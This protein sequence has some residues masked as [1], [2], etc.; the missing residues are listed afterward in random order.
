M[1]WGAKKPK[2][3][4]ATWRAEVILTCCKCGVSF[5][6]GYRISAKRAAKPQYCGLECRS[7]K[8]DKACET[9][10]KLFRPRSVAKTKFCS[11]ACNTIGIGFILSDE[12]RAKRSAALAKAHEEGRITH[13]KR[14]QKPNWKGGPKATFQRRKEKVD[15]AALL[16]AY[17]KANPD[18]V[19]EFSRRR[20]GK[21]LGRLPRGTLPA[22]RK[23]QRNRCAICAVSL[24]KGSHIDHITPISRGGLH[25]PRNI[26]FLCQHC[27][28]TKSGRDPI[29]H[30]QSLG[31]LL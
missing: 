12:V 22:I 7:F 1:V 17:R 23:A 5:D 27:N 30:M 31:R 28:L 15:T 19:R 2:D 24:K 25:E 20:K 16:R 26:Q 3:D 18:K 11:V 14:E 8:P 9:C 29:T 4:G 21:K 10:G 6:R 13:L